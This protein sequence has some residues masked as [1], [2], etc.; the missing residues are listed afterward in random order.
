MH[1]FIGTIEK[2]I[3]EFVLFLVNE[4]YENAQ[5]ECRNILVLTQ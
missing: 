2:C 1:I 5:S 4:R 3:S